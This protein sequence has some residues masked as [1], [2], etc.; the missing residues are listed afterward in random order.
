MIFSLFMLRQIC[1]LK[2]KSR[3]KSEYNVL[4]RTTQVSRKFSKKGRRNYKRS[5]R[6][7][8]MWSLIKQQTR[9]SATIKGIN[10]NK[11]QK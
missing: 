11:R 8:K 2:Y 4:M 5:G 6:Q 3:A 1:I 9:D 7:Q 10:K